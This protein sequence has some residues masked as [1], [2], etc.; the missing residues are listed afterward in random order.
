MVEQFSRRRFLAA[1][2]TAASVTILPS[3]SYGA[4][5]SDR[6]RTAHIGVGGMGSADL[7]SISSH[8]NVD[9][10]A[11]CDVDATALGKKTAKHTAAKSFAD[12]RVMF[13][14]MADGIDAVVVSTPDH[15]HAP[16]A[17]SALQL[18]KHVYCQKPLS[19]DVFESRCLTQAAEARGVVTQ[20]GIQVHSHTIYRSARKT[21]QS[22]TLG[23]IS[24][25][26][27][28]S[29]KNWGYDGPKTEDGDEAGEQLDW[30]LWLGTAPARPFKRSK[31]H[32]SQW[33]RYLDF[34]CGTL[35]DMGVH[36]F[37]TPFAALELTAPNWV[38]AACRGPT[39]EGFP[40]QNSV[41]FEFPGTRHTTDTLSVKWYDGA[42][43]PPKDLE[44]EAIE[45]Y[46]LPSQGMIC[47]GQHGVMV[48]PHLGLASLLPSAKFTEYKSP[49]LESQNHYH[50]WVDACLGNGTTSA[51]FSYAGP[52][53]EA[54]LLGSVAT[55]FPAQ[56]LQWNA[57]E[58]ATSLSAANQLIR[59]QYRK[60]FE[61]EALST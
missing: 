24:D 48:L 12:F 59:R 45:G 9:V 53:S 26:H 41:E 4:A 42:A 5:P 20:M 61:V 7:Q 6:L 2:G 14:E 27:V 10:V 40:E 13:D 25:V 11:L 54:L 23:K 60:G 33:R 44:L 17:M 52:L 49:Q 28:W 38:S 18:D 50:Q 51:P 56:R 34:G 39:G 43:A 3:W 29:S 1:A 8:P 16:A 37:D 32:P 21:L 46:T 35:G 22:G 19:H 30:N 31:Y 57:S 47:V 58:L 55:S 15:T 36:I